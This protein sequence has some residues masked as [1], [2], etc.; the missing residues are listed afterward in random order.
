MSVEGHLRRFEPAPA[1]SA[2]PPI[3]TNLMQRGEHRKGPIASFCD[4]A[5]KPS[6]DHRVAYSITSSA[7]ICMINGTVRPSVLAVLR[8]STNSNFADC[9][10]GRLAGFSPLRIRPV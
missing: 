2:L 4:A 6:R 8:L 10:T 7:V 1:T 5:N 9:I 3:A